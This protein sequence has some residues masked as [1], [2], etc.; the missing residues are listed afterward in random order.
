MLP[1]IRSYLEQVQRHL[2]LDP[3][4][5]RQL[6]GELDSHF[7][8]KIA[9][10]QARGV[11]EEEAVKAATRSF[12]RPRTVA[13]LM[14]EACSK[15]S[16]ADAL[17]ASLPHLIVAGLF[18]T[19]L[20]QN[21]VVALVVFAVNVGVTLF[22]WWGGKPNWLYSWIGYS[23]IPLVMGGYALHAVF[24][25]AF[26]FLL[27]RAPFPTIPTFI[28]IIILLGFFTWLIVSTTI[29]VVKRD[30]V[31]ASL[32]LVPL[33]ILAAWFFNIDLLGGPLQGG[34]PALHQW[35]YP[36]ALAFI[37]LGVNAAM[38]IRLRK[39]MLKLTAVM[40]IAF[41]ALVIVAH[42]IWGGLALLDQ[43]LLLLSVTIILLLMPVLI[44]KCVG[45]GE[46][47]STVWW[48]T[49]FGQSLAK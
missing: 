43:P 1:E 2:R 16:W 18:I 7:E 28:L 35:D 34:E 6:I 19:S 27:G 25:Q 3:A 36:M 26:S 48:N 47:R 9:E 8:E 30:W 31:L 39:R 20:W 45:H 33:P 5:E 22:G 41:I 12:G 23:L 42:S 32:M 17:L 21:A 29:R 40:V 13:R 24:A 37:T 44:E 38:F 10:L 11:R 4:L 14:Y 46:V 49:Y 15:G